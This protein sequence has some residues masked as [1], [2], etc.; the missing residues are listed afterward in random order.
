MRAL[1]VCL[2]LFATLGAGAEAAG[3]AGS[4]PPVQ[5]TYSGSM[6]VE[7]FPTTHEPGHTRRT[8]SWTAAASS[9]GSDGAM[10]LDFSSVSGSASLEGSGN[11]YDSSTTI[12]LWSARNPL[13]NGWR[14][15]ESPDYPASGWRYIALG[16]P[17]LVPVLE[18]I[19]GRCSSSQNEALLQPNEML[20]KQETFSP[21]QLAEYEALFDPLEFVPGRPATRTRSFSFD[22]TSHCACLPDPTHVTESMTVT[23]SATSPAAGNT[24]KTKAAPPPG[25]RPSATPPGRELSFARRE[26][27]K[28]EALEDG[29]PA[30]ERAWIMRGITLPGG[31]TSGLTLSNVY[32]ELGQ[33]GLF[34][35]LAK[36]G[37]FTDG[38][39][40]IIR[41]IN[42]Y[43]ISRDPPDRRF[44]LLAAPHAR[45]PRALPSCGSAPGPCGRLR[46][47]LSA[48][49]GDDAVAGGITDALLVTINRDSGAIA[50]HDYAAAQRQYLHFQSLHAQ[51]RRVLARR[52]SDGARVA[53]ILRVPGASGVLSSAGSARAIAAL[54]AQLVRAGIPRSRLRRIAGA[55]LRA[56]EV[57]AFSTL[58][59]PKG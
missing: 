2:V 42:D 4:L 45:T 24:I 15:D 12:A 38:D 8:A 20:L 37:L 21:A 33:D 17:D 34:G 59:S 40:A 52:G 7:I 10:A 19:K 29:V 11:C 6:S 47:A 56:R 53:A 18:D 13:A 32:T 1:A 54:E 46:E 44:R 9:G 25:R 31:L 57:D 50:A 43:R 5:I 23:V 27:L 41:V 58:A 36:E 30:L 22:G 39:E 48:M 55:A 3:A 28:I 14:L 16:V 49:L 51:L 35:E 26:R